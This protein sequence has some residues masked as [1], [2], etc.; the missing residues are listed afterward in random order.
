M[1]LKLDKKALEAI[2]L[3]GENAFPNEAC[4]FFYGE[5][6]E[7]IRY[8]HEAIPVLNA[9]EG[10]QR[11]RFEIS[12]LDYLKAERYAEESNTTLLGVYHSHPQ[13]PAIPSEHDLKQA[14]PYFSYIIISVQD[15]KG[16][17]LRSWQLN[18]RGEFEEELIDNQQTELISKF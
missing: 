14:V 3:D 10:D 9:K 7:G 18:E 5:E 16:D 6:K 12:P 17:H 4:G 11:R 1:K 2:Y 15:G 8:I 13:H